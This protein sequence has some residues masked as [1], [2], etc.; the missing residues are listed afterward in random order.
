MKILISD[1]KK[2]DV[3]VSLFQILK[4]CSST[5]SLT[6]TSE[7]IHIQGM[8]KSHVCL[9]DATINSE[10]FNEYEIKKETKKMVWGEPTWFLFHTIAEKVKEDHFG[11]IRVEL[12]NIIFTICSNLPCPI[13]TKHASDHLKGTNFNSIQTKQQLKDFL[14]DF[15]NIVNRRKG[16]PIFDYKQ[17][18][19]KYS[20][21]NTNLII[22]NFINYFSDKHKNTRLIADDFIRT[23]IVQRLSE[24]FYKNINSFDYSSPR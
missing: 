3:F 19:E 20:K 6:F 21:A 24:W 15:H 14:F 4:N 10:W 7:K 2:K 17:L 9:F 22:V 18:D 8:D 11:L 12:L 16:F 1:K 23:K 13:C 5:I